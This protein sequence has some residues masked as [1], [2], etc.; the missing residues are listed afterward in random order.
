MCNCFSD[1]LANCETVA[2]EMI[3]P[4][5]PLPIAKTTPLANETSPQRGLFRQGDP[6]AQHL[7]QLCACEDSNNPTYQSANLSENNPYKA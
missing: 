6:M 1:I 7:T 2:T 5:E 4:A 3:H